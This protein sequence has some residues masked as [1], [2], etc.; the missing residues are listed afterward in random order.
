MLIINL[1]STW[2]E[3]NVKTF[4]AINK[5]KYK[6]TKFNQFLNYCTHNKNEIEECP[7]I[8]I[9]A[10]ETSWNWN[11]KDNVMARYCHNSFPCAALTIPNH[12]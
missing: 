7:K 12:S 4:S 8:R 5:G 9:K 1:S 6:D 2:N 11:M 3:E 10:K